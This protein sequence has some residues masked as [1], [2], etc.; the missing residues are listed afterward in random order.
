MTLRSFFNLDTS[1]TTVSTN[2]ISCVDSNISRER[3]YAVLSLDT[4]LETPTFFFASVAVYQ[5]K[6][7][8]KPGSVRRLAAPAMVIYLAGQLPARSSGRP[9]NAITG[10][11][12]PAHKSR[13]LL[14]FASD[15]ACPA[16]NG[17]PPAGEL[18]PRHFTLTSLRFP[19]RGGIFSVALSLTASGRRILSVILFLK[20]GLSSTRRNAPRPSVS[21][22]D[23]CIGTDPFCPEGPNRGDIAV[24]RS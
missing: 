17:Y 19:Q 23:H 10:W 3:V 22:L 20:P 21:S 4:L 9:G 5:K 7:R 14:G 12:N 24:H 18:L 16:R 2:S 6:K 1:G 11:K 8:R 13:F 15:G